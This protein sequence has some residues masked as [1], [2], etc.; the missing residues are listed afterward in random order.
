MIFSLAR[1]LLVL[2]LVLNYVLWMRVFRSRVQNLR[3]LV[4]VAAAWWTLSLVII[5][6]GLSLGK[7][8]T[9]LGLSISW[10]LVTILLIVLTYSNKFRDYE[11]NSRGKADQAFEPSHT[12]E[13]LD[14]WMLAGMAFICFF[15][16]LTAIVSPPNGSD[17]LQYHLPRIVEWAQRH[18]VAFFP[19]H[20]YVQLF[21]PP[22]AEWTMM[23]TYILSAGDHFVNLVQWFAF[24]G[25]AVCAGLIAR[26]LG[27]NY[28]AQ[29]TAAFLCVT[30]PQG[31]LAA[32]GAKND[33]VLSFWLAAVVWFFLRFR[34]D[35]NVWN[36]CNCG[37]ALG[38][39][40]LSKGTA[41]PF[42]PFV[43]LACV[44]PLLA[45][46][47]KILLR[48]AP[49]IALVVLLMTGLQAARNFS[50]GGSIFG[51]SRPDVAGK[52]KYTV[53]RITI[54]GI[55]ANVIR[56]LAM[57]FS[58]PSD[59]INHRVTGLLRAVI[60]RMKVDPDDPGATNY[61]QFA[62]RHY[63]REEY[64]AGNP[65]HLLIIFFFFGFLLLSWRAFD[66]RVSLIAL[67]IVCSF[68]LYCALFRWEAM[69]PRL[70]LPLFVLSGAIAAIVACHCFPRLIPFAAVILFLSA[71]PPLFLNDLRP[72]L[73]AGNLR[74]LTDSDR[75]IFLRS[76]SELYFTEQRNLASTYIPAAALLTKTS[77]TDI[78]IDMSVQPVAHEYAL[79]ALGKVPGGESRFRYVDV[80]NLSSKYA[81]NADRQQPCA[82][83]CV[84]CR[85]H[86]EKWAEYLAAFPHSNVFGDLVIFNTGQKPETAT[87]TAR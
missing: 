9:P 85:N 78:G 63:S 34:R 39:A 42:L 30:L 75:S 57:N 11:V 52:E 66:P 41:Y 58:T 3:D 33:W 7:W 54:P 64:L 12:F 47:D 48:G 2:L 55:A 60:V 21:A 83:I 46:N 13:P 51:L 70:H 76:R 25:S 86:R 20:Y 36:A 61:A 73:F 84:D 74:H 14:R 50:L 24:M 26:E 4:V 49:A 23:H 19:S 5:T 6:E 67:A 72:L 65:L 15:V 79:M 35:S 16:G 18:S 56:E 53:D 59:A 22:L 32:S 87:L 43:L 29:V 82:V 31:I 81:T 44:I 28:R 17:Q 38:A 37:I 45:L 40:I 8:L 1:P 62:I 77:C 80:H 27:G 71:M 68:L 69:C 10:S